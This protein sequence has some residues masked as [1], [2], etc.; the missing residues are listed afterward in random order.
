MAPFDEMG[1]GLHEMNRWSVS[2]RLEAERCAKQ[3]DLLA[4]HF[5][6]PKQASMLL[7]ACSR[8][9]RQGKTEYPASSTHGTKRPAR[10][11]LSADA[12]LDLLL[13]PSRLKEPGV[14]LGG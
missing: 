11:S 14:W 7:R 8:A 4:G 2:T 9:F 1:R 6:L 13:N 3:G 10:R 5:P 12:G